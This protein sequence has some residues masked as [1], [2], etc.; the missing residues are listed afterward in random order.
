M[1]KCKTR[2]LCGEALQYNGENLDELINAFPT[3]NFLKLKSSTEF[4]GSSYSDIKI[5]DNGELLAGDWIVK[6]ST[7]LC[8]VPMLEFTEYWEVESV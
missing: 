2:S 8:L 3:L 4:N 7:G 1:I 5:E 6:N